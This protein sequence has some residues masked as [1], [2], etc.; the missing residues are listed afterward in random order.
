MREYAERV[1]MGDA[2]H[3]ADEWRDSAS[4]AVQGELVAIQEGVVAIAWELRALR[5]ALL[6]NTEDEDR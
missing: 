3:Q 4:E 6:G 1:S 5:L 2:A